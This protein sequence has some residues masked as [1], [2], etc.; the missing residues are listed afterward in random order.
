MVVKTCFFKRM[1]I[2]L[3]YVLLLGTLSCRIVAQKKDSVVLTTA[4]QRI[5]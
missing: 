2:Y 3:L 1:M 4:L 5:L